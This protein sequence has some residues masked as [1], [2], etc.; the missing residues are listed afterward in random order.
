MLLLGAEGIEQKEIYLSSE[1][2]LNNDDLDFQVDSESVLRTDSVDGTSIIYLRTR[3]S[4]RCSK[5][6]W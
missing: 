5:Y 6:C 3:A 1:R 4:I 2:P